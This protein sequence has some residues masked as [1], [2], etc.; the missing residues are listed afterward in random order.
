MEINW[1]SI[2][3]ILSTPPGE[4]VYHLLVGFALMLI[5]IS[6]LDRQDSEA[7]SPAQ[8]HVL[9]GVGIVL[10]LHFLLFLFDLQ[11]P[12]SQVVSSHIE[13]TIHILTLVWLTW[14]FIDRD[15]SF[16]ITGACIFLSLAFIIGAA[17]SAALSLIVPGFSALGID[18]LA[19]VWL[20]S[21]LFLALGGIILL[22]LRRPHQWGAGLGILSILALGSSLVIFL[23]A[24]EGSVFGP[25]RL[26]QALSLPWMII[27][28]QRFHPLRG[29]AMTQE[30]MIK[31]PSS[32]QHVDIKPLLIDQLLQINL[33][34]TPEN[35]VAAVAHALSLG[36]VADMC[37]LAKI[38]PGERK[39]ALLAGY[40]LIREKNLATT[41][42]PQE[43]LPQIMGAWKMGQAYAPP[44]PSLET[45]DAA[46]LTEILN[47]HRIGNIL[48]YPLFLE[49]HILAGG[50]LILSPYTEKRWGAKDLAL[51]GKIENALTAVLFAPDPLLKLN[52]EL[53]YSRQKAQELQN[54][55][56]ALSLTLADS[57]LKINDQEVEIKRLKAKYQIEKLEMA[58]QVEALQEK[59]LRF[60][61][62]AAAYQQDM[63]KLE[64]LNAKIRSLIS[65]KARLESDLSAANERIAALEDQTM[66]PR[67]FQEAL[68]KEIISLDAIA[69][70]LRLEFTPRCQ[71][72]NLKLEIENSD[73][74][75][76]I[77][78]DSLKLQT[79][80]HGLLENALLASQ[81]GGILHF[82]I[83]LSYETGMLLLQVSDAGE[84]LSP[85]EQQALFQE[86]SPQ[87]SGVGSI[88]ALREAVSAIR[89]L[90]GKIWL[91]SQKGQAT[92]IRVQLPVRIID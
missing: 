19:L 51:M 82:S 89:A 63:A 84:G 42:L 72:K 8:N 25:I 76:L 43:D 11:A 21:S 59:I 77:K 47:F 29:R 49:N 58:N 3:N 69:A 73:G 41:A 40:D 14:S 74:S 67:E 7:R 16:L 57:Q 4:L 12:A 17:L 48:A 24:A 78:A 46:T 20:I 36:L 50:V 15:K 23:P 90:K 35:K 53:A 80:L 33:Q 91:R 88:K 32:N 45:K 38:N 79:V 64:S 81:P 92:T 27:L 65:E 62:Q 60:S 66:A 86:G 5:F 10:A 6:A 56:R 26:A 18:W 61:S 52:E 83:G 44:F 39:V 30:A 70:N 37:Y 71:R 54:K 28:L 55:T 34:E 68:Q 31:E 1:S 87:P 13:S 9:V 75:Q 22:A 85:G 2:F